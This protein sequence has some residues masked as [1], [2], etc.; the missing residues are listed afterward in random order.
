MRRVATTLKV[1]QT[2]VLKDKL[3]T[4]LKA[5]HS[6]G[7]AR[8]VGNVQLELRDVKTHSKHLERLRS[9]ADVEVAH[10]S[11]EK[12]QVL[13]LQDDQVICMHP[14]SYDQVHVAPG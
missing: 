11:A 5:T 2:V 4:I 12:W 13:Y 8:Q 3:Y 14:E 9:S 7:T 10:L 6:Q 1:G